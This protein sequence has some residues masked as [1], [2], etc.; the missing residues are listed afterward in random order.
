MNKLILMGNLTRD[1][2]LKGEDDKLRGVSSIALNQKDETTFVDLV[3][4][5]KQA[6]NAAKYLNKGRQ[7]LVEGKLKIFNGK[8][9]KFISCQ[10]ERFYFVNDGKR[11]SNVT[12]EEE[13]Y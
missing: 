8:E 6:E 3:F 12:T 5:G 1:V 2:E 11:E 7:V 4:W 10:V 13:P 9:T